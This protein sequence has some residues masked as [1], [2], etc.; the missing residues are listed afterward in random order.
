MINFINVNYLTI[1]FHRNNPVINKIQANYMIYL[2]H[3]NNLINSS[4]GSVK[5]FTDPLL[6][7]MNTFIL[8]FPPVFYIL[9]SFIFQCY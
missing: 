7:I 8:F 2:V 1:F 9:I 4:I 3:I 6:M 5:S